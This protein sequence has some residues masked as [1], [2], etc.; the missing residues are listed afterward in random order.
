MSENSKSDPFHAL[1]HYPKEFELLLCC[2]GPRMH[3]QKVERM[4]VV[5]AEGLDWELV[6]RL[7][8]WHHMLPLLYWNLIHVDA[9][10]PAWI[11][12]SL[13]RAFN[14]NVRQALAMTGEL[15]RIIDLLG[16][17]KIVAVPYKGP[18]LAD[19]L[20]G[21]IALRQSADL[22]IIVRRCDVE[23]ARDILIQR[24]Y[25]PSV[26]VIGANRDFQVE[27]RYSER[28][29]RPDSVVELHWA[30]T[31][32]DV[33]FPLTLDN[34]LPRLT[35]HVLFGKKS[36]LA[37]SPED[38]LLILCVHGAKHSWDRLEWIC[39]IAELI[40]T[41][42]LDWSG[43]IARAIETR[44]SRRLLL[45]LSLSH[46]LYGVRVPGRV[47]ET[48]KNDGEIRALL[49]HVT[50]LLF[51]GERNKTGAH[52]FGTLKHDL[53]HFK[54]ADRI[55]DRL[56]YVAYRVTNPSR[57]ERWSA[58]SIGRR[59]IPIHAFTRPV[60]LVAKIIHAAWRRARGR[61]L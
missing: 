40:D 9:P 13:K 33:V 59:S 53:F 41:A 46:D 21:N 12:E 55:P 10:V 7:A 54:L 36:I 43:L 37:F 4:Q 31:N 47:Q 24:G 30:F 26:M 56:R 8:Y 35:E 61:A 2:G 51:D 44:S 50:S 49:L 29:D 27:S 57:P 34:L 60:G 19:R 5:L 1:P 11:M 20:Y 16:E 42:Q 28:F 32:K 25:V 17:R 6:F 38:T 22:D 14:Q 45:G 15:L 39:G 3:S 18:V 58:V 23:G 52:S 48:I